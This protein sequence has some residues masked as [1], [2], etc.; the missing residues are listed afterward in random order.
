MTPAGDWIV[1]RGRAR[2]K[3]DL[4]CP[5]IALSGCT[6]V[7]PG[8][9]ETATACAAAAASA[10]PLWPLP[11]C[12]PVARPW[13]R[14]HPRLPTPVCC[15]SPLS[16]HAYPACTHTVT[17]HASGRESSCSARGVTMYSLFQSFSTLSM[18]AYPVVGV[19]RRSSRSSCA[20]ISI[21]SSDKVR[22]TEGAEAD[23]GK[24]GLEGALGLQ[25]C[26]TGADKVER[27]G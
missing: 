22:S 15:C 13:T 16:L 27:R 9:A 11:R 24:E 10:Q 26:G 18:T 2:L 25:C 5:P 21:S 1:T 6:G 7:S 14:I 17:A 12:W 23:D 8:S 4:S 19:T 20:Y 3:N